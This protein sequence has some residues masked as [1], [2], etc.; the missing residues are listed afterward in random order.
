MRKPKLRELREAV[1]A[2]LVGPVT[3]RFPA[4]PYVPVDVFRGAPRYFEDDCIGC[5]ACFEVCPARAIHLDDDTN[6]DPP[7]RVLTIHHDE[8]IFCGH[9]QINC[10]ADKKG[11]Q[12]TTDWD[13]AC[14]DRSELRE[15]IEH[16][17]VI[18]E[19]CGCG[20]T[21]K[22]HLLWIAERLGAKRYANPTLVLTADRE[23]GLLEP[24]TP[25]PQDQPVDRHDIMRVLCPNCRRVSVV[26]EMW[27]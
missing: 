26:K 7:K 20:I 11:V 22:K 25:R 6:A 17:L 8:C 19:L 10:T 3:T 24:L 15:P 9:C 13:L 16:E 18:C 21:A 14:F 12:Q 5:G 2:L 27:G 4:E 1:K 23:M